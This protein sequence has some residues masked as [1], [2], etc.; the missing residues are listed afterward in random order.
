[1]NRAWVGIGGN[2]GDPVARVEA[3][4]DALGILAEG[5]LVRSSLY[6]TPPWGVTDQP[7]FVNA[8]ATFETRLDAESLL[9]ALLVIERELGRE[10]DAAVRWGPRVID[11]DLLLLGDSCIDTPRLRLP[12]PLIA[13][14]AFVL[15]PMNELDPD[16]EVPG[17][18]R[19]AALLGRV[20]ARG[21]T[22]IE[23]EDARAEVR[24]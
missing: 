10:R 3:A 4:V 24:R 15:V 21:V 7:D 18:G 9:E 23:A 11:L 13:E 6:R 22:R 1:M 8:V 19:V 14:R 2:L 16:L 12:H 20:D 5:P 17:Q